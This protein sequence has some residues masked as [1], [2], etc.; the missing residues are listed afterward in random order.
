MKVFLLSGVIL[1]RLDNWKYNINQLLLK[2]RW[3]E[4]NNCLQRGSPLS[5][6]ESSLRKYSIEHI[7]LNL[8]FRKL[9]FIGMVKFLVA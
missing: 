3:C 6:M 4:Y 5:T 7:P 2:F 8:Y 9:S 1:E